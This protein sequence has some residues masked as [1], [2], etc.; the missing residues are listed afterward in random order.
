MKEFPLTHSTTVSLL[1]LYVRTAKSVRAKISLRISPTA[2]VTC[3]LQEAVR[4]SFSLYFKHKGMKAILPNAYIQKS[5][6][7]VRDVSHNLQYVTPEED[8]IRVLKGHQ[9][10]VTC[11]AVTPDGRCVYSGSKDC[12][13]IKCKIPSPVYC[14][15]M[16][17]HVYICVVTGLIF[18]PLPLEVAT[19]K[20]DDHYLHTL[21]VKYK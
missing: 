3:T 21:R 2:R 6:R 13:I 16:Y 15:R 1:L 9:L 5:T 19:Y 8:T 11:V 20:I 18:R 4:R 12:S 17:V 7:E 14:V 10:P